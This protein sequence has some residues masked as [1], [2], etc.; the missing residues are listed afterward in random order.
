[1]QTNSQHT[2]LPLWLEVLGGQGFQMC[3]MGFT[4]KG[5]RETQGRQSLKPSV[6]LGLRCW[7]TSTYLLS[8]CSCRAGGRSFR[9][10]QGLGPFC[11]QSPALHLQPAEFQLRRQG[12]A[13]QSHTQRAL[14]CNPFSS[15]PAC[16]GST[17]SPVSW[18]RKYFY[19]FHSWWRNDLMLW[20]VFLR[21]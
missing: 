10:K 5:I 12:T 21:G 2:K 4:Q 17:P 11:P 18:V 20:L 9:G 6:N 15:L 7:P 1:M 19:C 3:T 14:L 16:L 13:P 8:P